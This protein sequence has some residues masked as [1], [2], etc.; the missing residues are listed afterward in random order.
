MNSCSLPLAILDEE[1][2]IIEVNACFLE[3]FSS[4]SEKDENFRGESIFLFTDERTGDEIKRR[5]RQRSMVGNF[6]FNGNFV[7]NGRILPSKF[8]LNFYC[9]ENNSRREVMLLIETLPKLRIEPNELIRYLG[10]FLLPNVPLTSQIIGVN[11]RVIYTVNWDD[12]PPPLKKVEKC[13]RICCHV[14]KK[15]NKF[16]ECICDKVIA[17]GKTLIE[18][19]CIENNSRD[20]VWV[21]F[22]VIPIIGEDNCVYGALSTINNITEERKLAK[23]IEEYLAVLKNISMDSQLLPALV[24]HLKEPISYILSSLSLLME[25]S[26]IESSK[27]VAKMK[28]KCEECGE[29]INRIS[30]FS[31]EVPDTFLKTE[32]NALVR[33][34]VLPVFSKSGEKKV[35][36][37][38]THTPVYIFCSPSQFA[39]A[40]IEIIGNCF[41]YATREVLVSL[42]C[43]GDELLIDVEDD[44]EGIPS[45]V[46]SR[47]FTPFFTTDK[48]SGHL[49]LGL[50]L[51]KSIIESIGGSISLGESKFGGASFTIRLPIVEKI[52]MG[53][54]IESK[55]EENKAHILIV[56]D[57][58]DLAEVLKVS[59]ER[60]GYIVYISKECEKAK[61]IIASC[62]VSF[63]ILDL[64]Y[65]DQ[66]KGLQLYNEVTEKLKFPKERIIVITGDTANPLTR[67][68]LKN[69]RSPY[70]EKPFELEELKLL[71]SRIVEG[72]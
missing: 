19:V 69:L 20:Q 18:E 16:V 34:M 58:E 45:D 33:S 4:S 22:V 43:L 17:E 31:G 3:I 59:L 13:E 64:M 56:E 9:D 66:P 24:R 38:F 26:S 25:T 32:V 12:L 60:E 52:R 41:R 35:V 36:F 55:K 37:R 68:F 8:R 72:K 7:V 46:M 40:L 28:Q 10:E 29:I 65:Y 30:S 44:G 62:P 61:E 54:S 57:D 15:R 1:G 11:K 5:L 6:N 42:T 47:I 49:G 53:E 27:L 63:I 21:V 14:F 48:S 39:H 23:G 2:R 51:A 71:V 50:S 70:L 67:N